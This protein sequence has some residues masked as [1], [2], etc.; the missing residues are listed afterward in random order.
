[1]THPNIEMSKELVELLG[2]AAEIG[3]RL[4][5]DKEIFLAAAWSAFLDARPGL[6]EELADRELGEQLQTLRERGLI[7]TA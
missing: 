5:I 3:S 2:R 4:G 1:M 7:A 6:R